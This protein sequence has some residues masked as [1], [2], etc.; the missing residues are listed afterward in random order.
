MGDLEAIKALP[1]MS[2]NAPGIDLGD[3]RILMGQR[4]TTTYTVAKAFALSEMIEGRDPTTGELNGTKE[5][6]GQEFNSIHTP[7]PLADRY[8]SILVYSATN[9]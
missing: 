7:K 2:T 3:E 5:A 9:R 1:A 6:Y 4:G 8:T